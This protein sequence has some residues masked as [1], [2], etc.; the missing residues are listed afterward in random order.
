MSTSALLQAVPGLQDLGF[1]SVDFAG[2]RLW[3]FMRAAD[4]QHLLVMWQNVVAGPEQVKV[5]HGH[6]Q[7][8]R[9]PSQVSWRSQALHV[10]S[11]LQV[12][13]ARIVASAPAVSQ[14]GKR[15]VAQNFPRA[16]VL[17]GKER[18]GDNYLHAFR[19]SDGGWVESQD[20]F[21][22]VPP[23]VLQNLAGQATFSNSDLVLAIVGGNVVPSTTPASATANAATASNGYRIVL[24]FLGGKYVMEGRSGEEGALAVAAQFAQALQQSRPDLA[25]AWLADPKLISIPKYIGY[26]SKPAPEAKIVPMSNPN[27]AVTRFRIITGLTEDL[28]VDIAKTKTLPLAVKAMFI[29]PPDPLAQKILSNLHE[30]TVPSERLP[31]DENGK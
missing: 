25:K 23:Y 18:N 13:E 17:I 19:V 2:G 31:A 22:G 9:G 27:G 6:R 10:P 4:C 24:H 12:R 26:F 7:V 15:A 5:V 28:I 20:V 14:A 1:K 21:A 29:A 3:N 16:L 30:K 11:G 8:V